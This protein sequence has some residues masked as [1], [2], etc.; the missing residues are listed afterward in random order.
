MNRP[1]SQVQV[2]SPNFRHTSVPG[3]LE[4]LKMIVLFKQKTVWNLKRETFPTTQAEADTWKTSIWIVW[5]ISRNWKQGFLTGCLRQ[6]QLYCFLSTLHSGSTLDMQLEIY[7]NVVYSK[8]CLCFLSASVVLFVW[9]IFPPR[10][11]TKLLQ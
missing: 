9:V 3:V 4:H 7:K 6:S 2:P 5:K 10:I 11:Q 8:I 1:I